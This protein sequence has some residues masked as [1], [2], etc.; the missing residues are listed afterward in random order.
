[1]AGFYFSGART[2]RL[3]FSVCYSPNAG[4]SGTEYAFLEIIIIAG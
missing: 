3:G 2:A 1:M 4:I